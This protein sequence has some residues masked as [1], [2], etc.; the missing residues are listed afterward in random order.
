MNELI[1]NFGVFG[2]EGFDGK[3]FEGFGEAR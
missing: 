2:V 3:V 1:G